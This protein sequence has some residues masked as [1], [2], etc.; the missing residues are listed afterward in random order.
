[1]ILIKGYSQQA[2]YL[3]RQNEIYANKIKIHV[4]LYLLLNRIRLCIDDDC[5][6][7]KCSILGVNF[8]LEL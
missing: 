4:F 6:C 2:Y 8:S 5:V 7:Y 1:M 3:M